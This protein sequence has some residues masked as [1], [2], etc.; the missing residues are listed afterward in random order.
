MISG[1]SI[2]PAAGP[3]PAY[4]NHTQERR[5]LY[6]VTPATPL[7]LCVSVCLAVCLFV[8]VSVCLCVGHSERVSGT[9]HYL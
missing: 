9:I 6:T 4:L 8:C 5:L 1:E 3:Q 2:V 7:A